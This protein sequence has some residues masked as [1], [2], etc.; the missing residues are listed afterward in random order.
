[1][2]L[3]SPAEHKGKGKEERGNMDSCSSVWHHCCNH[4][5]KAR[6][7]QHEGPNQKKNEASSCVQLVRG[8]RIVVHAEWVVPG[9]KKNNG[10]QRLRWDLCYDVGKYKYLPR[11]RTRPLFASLVDISAFEKLRHNKL[12]HIAKCCHKHKYRKELVLNSLQAILRLVE[13]KA[14]EKALIDC[15]SVRSRDLCLGKLTIPRNRKS[16]IVCTNCCPDAP[17][18]DFLSSFI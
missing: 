11:I 16:F 9:H 5:R 1:M 14:I 3:D 18:S 6:A 17:P 7:E 10:H 12:H 2:E 13:G 8:Q 15:Q 4:L